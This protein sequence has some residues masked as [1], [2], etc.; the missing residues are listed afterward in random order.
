M[1]NHWRGEWSYE[2]PF[3]VLGICG[4]AATGLLNGFKRVLPVRLLKLP[5]VAVEMALALTL[6]ALS[7]GLVRFL[8]PQEP[9]QW[10]S[11]HPGM[12]RTE[13]CARLG[14]PNGPVR[15]GQTR[16][17]WAQWRV[18]GPINTLDFAAVFSESNRLVSIYVSKAPKISKGCRMLRREHEKLAP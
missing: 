4:L 1:S 12:D 15:N 18:S 16:D 6:T 17:Q 5:V 9:I 14:P 10:S 8:E 7:I 2:L 3:V 13:V 11:V